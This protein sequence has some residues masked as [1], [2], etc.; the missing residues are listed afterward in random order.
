M[1][2]SSTTSVF[3]QFIQPLFLKVKATESLARNEIHCFFSR[4]DKKL[5]DLKKRFKISG[6]N[7]EFL[8]NSFFC[9]YGS[10][11]ILC[12]Y[13]SPWER[14]HKNVFILCPE[15]L[16]LPLLVKC[17][18]HRQLDSLISFLIGFLCRFRCQLQFSVSCY[19]LGWGKS[20]ILPYSG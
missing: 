6:D 2:P 7:M 16:A 4:Y 8:K 19:L 18:V 3:L 10:L 5:Q 20:S 13:G 11:L 12:S 1:L 17:P 9:S 15:T 14:K